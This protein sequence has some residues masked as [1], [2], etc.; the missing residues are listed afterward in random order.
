MN[1]VV[2]PGTDCYCCLVVIRVN[3]LLFSVPLLK[4]YPQQKRWHIQC[5]A[6]CM[7]CGNLQP[8]T[9]NVLG[10]YPTALSQGRFTYCHDMV[11]HYLA[12]K[13]LKCFAGLM[14]DLAVC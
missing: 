6:K 2:G 1:Q 7:L 3:S 12:T 11:L 8:T 10:S 13:L 14:C 9:A 4:L 5:S